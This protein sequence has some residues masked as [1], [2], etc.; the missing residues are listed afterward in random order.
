MA[1][2][3]AK[4]VS[5]CMQA[6][7]APGR[8]EHVLKHIIA[9]TPAQA[10]IITL[11]DKSTCQIVNDDAL[12]QEYH[13]PLIQGFPLEAVTYYLEELRTI[14]PWAEAQRT[15]YPFRPTLMSSVCHP[16]EVEDKRFFGWLAQGGLRDTVAFEL[17]RFP[18]HWT[19]INL[20]LSEIDKTN[21][22]TLLD[23]CAAH[24]DI[25]REAWR[26]GQH[27]V[28][29][30]QS[31]QAA[32][33]Q[34]SL[35]SIPACI[36]TPDGEIF[37][38]NE[39]FSGLKRKGLAKTSEPSGRLSVCANAEF[40]GKDQRIIRKLGRHD[41]SQ[42]ECRVAISTFEPDPLYTDKREPHWLL[43]FS[44]AG[45]PHQAVD[46][47]AIDRSD[48]D[49]RERK[50]FDAICDGKSVEDAAKVIGV[51]RA[52]AYKVWDGMKG[53]LGVSNTHELRG[54]MSIYGG[55]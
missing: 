12:E 10:A 20:F 29:C 1:D 26:S 53:K 52:Q 28:H 45:G 39:A 34:L 5:L 51:S 40:R 21:S 23:F 25:L 35:R 7:R 54:I 31:G 16:D 42:S 55:K 3:D 30:Q 50:L 37:R 46:I 13:S 14:D 38:S 41:A 48:L 6:I 49:A 2:L 47:P 36:V 8:W 24:F 44:N 43:S 32:L 19:A 4:L 15:H 18:G 17:D 22:Q 33:E 11:R 9:T 27:M